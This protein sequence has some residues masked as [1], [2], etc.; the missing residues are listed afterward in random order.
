MPRATARTNARKPCRKN[1]EIHLMAADQPLE[2]GYPG[3]R[4]RECD[5][6][7]LYVA[8]GLSLR[9]PRPRPAVQPV[10]AVCVPRFDPVV[11]TLARYP[12]IVS[13]GQDTF[14]ARRA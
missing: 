7:W 14:T 9:G 10:R 1:N 8:R 4:L 2:F 13:D 11:Q 6:L 5:R 3:V 12:K